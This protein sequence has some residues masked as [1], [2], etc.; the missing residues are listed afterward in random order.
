MA[1]FLTQPSKKDLKYERRSAQMC[2]LKKKK[3]S[4]LKASYKSREQM[5]NNHIILTFI[6]TAERKRLQRS[7]NPKCE[8]RSAAADVQQAK[9][10][11]VHAH[12][13]TCAYTNAQLTKDNDEDMTRSSHIFSV[14]V[15]L[16]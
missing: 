11:K 10:I 2:C 7:I 12:T 6:I 8:L 9:I 13:H 16:G 14:S 3:N 5:Q 15:S 4:E 1:T